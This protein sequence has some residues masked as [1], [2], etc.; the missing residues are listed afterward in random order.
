MVAH[1]VLLLLV[2]AALPGCGG[3]REDDAIHQTST[4][5]A[6][7]AGAFAGVI[8]VES[9]DR[10]GT[11]GLGTFDGLD[12]ELVQV[13]GVT[14][15]VPVDGEVRAA[16]PETT[17]PFATTVRFDPHTSGE[18]QSGDFKALCQALDA[19][20]PDTQRFA[21]VRVHGQFARVQVRSVPKQEPPYPPLADAV[22]RQAVFTLEDVTGDIIGFRFPAHAK[23]YGVDGW[24]LHFLTD[25]RRQGGHLLAVT[26]TEAEAQ[27]MI[28]DRMEL[29]LPPNLPAALPP[30]QGEA[31]AKVE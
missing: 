2:L 10:Q 18:I 13:D 8:S 20:A 9:L 21:A 22:A 3:S 5:D 27:V 23:S 11:L 7:K 16:P 17:I 14:Y 24:H 15:Q 1:L 6:L 25:D 4:L 28:L 29:Y 30:A 19:L 26:T 31:G 12:G